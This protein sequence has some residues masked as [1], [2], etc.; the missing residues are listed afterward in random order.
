MCLVLSGPGRH[1]TGDAGS[2]G[3]AHA[4]SLLPRHGNFGFFRINHTDR[5]DQPSD[6]AFKTSCVDFQ[7]T[8]LAQKTI[9]EVVPG[10]YAFMSICLSCHQSRQLSSCCVFFLCLL[11]ETFSVPM[12]LLLSSSYHRYPVFEKLKLKFYYFAIPFRP[13]PLSTPSLHTYK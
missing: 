7:I 10:S 2:E 6:S 13:S 8:S 11:E 9:S 4:S 12:T 5:S 1:H 3:D